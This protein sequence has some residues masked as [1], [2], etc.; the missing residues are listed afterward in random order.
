MTAVVLLCF[1]ILIVIHARYVCGRCLGLAADYS[2]VPL[3]AFGVDSSIG[4]V[5]TI[6]FVNRVALCADLIVTCVP[7]VSVSVL[8]VV[9]VVMAGEPV[10]MVIA[11]AQVISHSLG[12]S[13][14]NKS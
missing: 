14:I 12:R 13:L 6:C 4:T 9:L 5:F 7:V 10:T 8:T 3:V 1:I 2:V 11:N